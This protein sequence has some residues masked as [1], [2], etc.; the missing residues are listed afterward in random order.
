M[1]KFV[2]TDAVT[3][4]IATR[5]ENNAAIGIELQVSLKKRTCE[6]VLVGPGITDGKYFS[7][8]MALAEYP[9]QLN[10]D[11]F[12]RD[13]QKALLD[14]GIARPGDRLAL[15]NLDEAA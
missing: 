13:M 3:A 1:G 12:F 2:N 4:A 11:N 10:L 9:D 8:S 14:S 5:G 6:I 7:Q 15:V